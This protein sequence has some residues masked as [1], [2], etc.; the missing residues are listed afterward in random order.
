MYKSLIG[1]L[2]VVGLAAV[3]SLAQTTQNQPAGQQPA[4]QQSQA[5]PAQT[6][7]Q[8]MQSR[9]ASQEQVRGA[10]N[11]SGFQEVTF[12][13]AAYLV[14]ALAPSGETVMMVVNP[15]GMMSNLLQNQPATTSSTGGQ[16]APAGGAAPQNQSGSG[17]TTK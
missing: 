12:V 17:Q 10:L 6:P 15:S 13:D 7:E 4:G 9:I 14:T 3:P 1:A 2:A 11:T 5:Q 16:A 8:Q